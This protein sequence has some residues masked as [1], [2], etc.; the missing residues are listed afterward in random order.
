MTHTGLQSIE[1]DI[2]GIKDI[3]VVTKTDDN[4]PAYQCRRDTYFQGALCDE[5]Y[6]TDVT[7]TSEVTGT[8]HGSTNHTRGLRPLCWFKPSVK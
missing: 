7:A 8:C 2:K 3:S 6:R 4:H 5:D 1:I